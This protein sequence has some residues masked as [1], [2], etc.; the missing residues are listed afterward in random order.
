MGK[1]TADEIGNALYA[2]VTEG[3]FDDRSSQANIDTQRKRRL[4]ENLE[5]Q[6]ES[7]V[8][9]Q[10]ERGFTQGVTSTMQRSMRNQ[11]KKQFKEEPNVIRDENQNEI[12]DEYEI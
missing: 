5:K 10:V 9:K 3:I 6:K 11:V 7:S 8:M 2:A 12:D 1:Y 4:L